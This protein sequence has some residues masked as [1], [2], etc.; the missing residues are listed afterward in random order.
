MVEAERRVVSNRGGPEGAVPPG[1]LELRRPQVSLPFRPS[2]S[3]LNAGFRRSCRPSGRLR[4]AL[5]VSKLRVL[6][7]ALLD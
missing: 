5:L 3:P 2:A 7:E 6:F 1:A 4:I